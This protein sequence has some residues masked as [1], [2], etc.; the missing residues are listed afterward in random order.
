VAEQHDSSPAD[1][2]KDRF[3]RP[4]RVLRKVELTGR[5]VDEAHSAWTKTG[6]PF[7]EVELNE[8]GA[9]RMRELSVQHLHEELAI[10]L[11]GKLLENC[12]IRSTMSHHCEFGGGSEHYTDEQA[13]QIAE[14]INSSRP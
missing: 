1:D 10:V 14:G 11:D 5:D 4:I 8:P 3:G 9:K 12:V 13:D 6:I 7:V 2:M